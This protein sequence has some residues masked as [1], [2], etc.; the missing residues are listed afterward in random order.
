MSLCL[1]RAAF[2]SSSNPSSSSGAGSSGGGGASGGVG[3]SARRV[4]VNVGL[5]LTYL[6]RSGM[7]REFWTLV[8]VDRVET[9]GSDTG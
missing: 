5:R 7:K 4:R 3:V 1:R 9:S 6:P 2:S 8:R